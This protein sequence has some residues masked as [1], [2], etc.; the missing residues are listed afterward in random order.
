MITSDQAFDL[1]VE[2]CPSYWATGDFTSYLAAFEEPD[3]PDLY[4]RASAFVLHLVD[5]LASGRTAELDGV[6]TVIERVLTEGDPDAIEL[7]EIGLIEVLQNVTS[8]ED[9]PVDPP[10]VEALLG[11]VAT[12]V[13]TEHD[14]LWREAGRWLHDGP[15]VEQSDYDAIVDPSLRRYFQAHKRQLA[16]GTLISASDIV[17][18]Q[19]ELRNISPLTPAGRPQVPWTALAVGLILAIAAAIAKYR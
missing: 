11:P 7:I 3:T 9:V 6:S 10:A 2:A 12:K 19:V 1:L 4:L 16:D 13:W 8:H 5:L 17:H 18:Y 15:R 14:E